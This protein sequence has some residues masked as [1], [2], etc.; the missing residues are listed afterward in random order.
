MF[1]EQHEEEVQQ[2]INIDVRIIRRAYHTVQIPLLS[3]L[4]DKKWRAKAS[5]EQN[6]KRDTYGAGN[7]GKI[8]LQL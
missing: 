1:D 5:A 3:S 2:F 6:D 7:F 8:N 4:T